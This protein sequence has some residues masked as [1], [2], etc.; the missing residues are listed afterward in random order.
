MPELVELK[1]TDLSPMARTANKG[2]VVSWINADLAN[3]AGHDVRK[4]IV[5][6]DKDR[7][8]MPELG[9][10]AVVFPDLWDNLLAKPDSE[11]Q[12]TLDALY[13]AGARYW[14]RGLA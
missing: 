9:A 4:S 5:F 11:K 2:I 14:V 8:F 1:K 7:V 13:Q 12:V 10:V 3:R 6:L